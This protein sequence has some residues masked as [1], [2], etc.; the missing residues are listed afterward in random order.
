MLQNMC[1]LRRDK[2]FWVSNLEKQKDNTQSYKHPVKCRMD[3]WNYNG[4]VDDANV[5]ALTDIR[6][7]GSGRGVARD[8]YSA[9]LVSWSV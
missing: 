7:D 4:H 8:L 9:S 2:E 5:S 1:N 6:C 3:K